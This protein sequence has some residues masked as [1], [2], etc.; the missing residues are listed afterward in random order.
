LCLD[1]GGAPAATSVQR[2]LAHSQ[3]DSNDLD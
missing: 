1:N 3:L 2:G